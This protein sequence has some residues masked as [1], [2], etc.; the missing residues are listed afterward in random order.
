MQIVVPTNISEHMKDFGLE[1][2][3]MCSDPENQS[4]WRAIM[5]KLLLQP[6]ISQQLLFSSEWSIWFSSHYYIS[7][8]NIKIECEILN[9]DL[10]HE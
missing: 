4:D 5:E 10:V 3:E 1:P 7:Q 2:L 6:C 8:Y 9:L